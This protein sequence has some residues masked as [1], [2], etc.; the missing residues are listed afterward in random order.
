[1]TDIS[2]AEKRRTAGYHIGDY[3]RR[4]W[5]SWLVTNVSTPGNVEYCEK[6]IVVA[7]KQILSLQSHKLR[8]E[9]WNVLEGNIVA[10]VNDACVPLGSG[11]G[12]E[13]PAGA[14]HSM[15]NL[16]DEP[17]IIKERQ[18]GIC[19]ESDIIRYLDAYGRVTARMNK[20]VM[21]TVNLYYALLEQTKERQEKY[22]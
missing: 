20:R 14:P 9:T 2:N 7:P 8:H 17:C 4:P 21:K 11:Q 6:V 22:A 3:D 5:G 15:A 10:L 1:M 19:R 13:I 16:S 18:T 12:I